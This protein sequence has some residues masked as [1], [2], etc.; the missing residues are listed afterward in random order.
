MYDQPK[1]LATV[2]KHDAAIVRRNSTPATKNTHMPL[3]V[4]KQELATRSTS[5]L[6]HSNLESRGP[7]H[8]EE[9]YDT[10]ITAKNF[11]ANRIAYMHDI[12]A[13][14][15]N[16]VTAAECLAEIAMMS[17]E[18]VAE[19]YRAAIAVCETLTAA[20]YLLVQT[21]K[22]AWTVGTLAVIVGRG[23]YRAGKSLWKRMFA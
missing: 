2:I 12:G 20:A 7:N 22:S 9:S 8:N 4:F 10:K 6:H 1:P 17:R 16:E 5:T 13:T 21:C 15:G 18:I 23:L 14:A 19:G 11:N 3:R